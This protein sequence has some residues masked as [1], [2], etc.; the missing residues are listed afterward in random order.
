[1]QQL[2]EEGVD[3]LGGEF[4]NDP[5]LIT[6][7]RQLGYKD[8]D[9]YAK[10]M[11]FDKKKAKAKFEEQSAVVQRHENPTK[12]KKEPIPGGGIDTTGQGQDRLGGFGDPP[13][14]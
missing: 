12:A 1:M 9:E 3:H 14:E 11:G 8:V 7:V 13:K 5:E 10:I 4:R 6:R 2:F